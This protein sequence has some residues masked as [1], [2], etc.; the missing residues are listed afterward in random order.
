MYIGS[1]LTNLRNVQD[2]KTLF[3]NWVIVQLSQQIT[4]MNPGNI[5]WKLD[6]L[7]HRQ[8]LVQG[9]GSTPVVFS[10]RSESVTRTLPTVH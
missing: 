6:S 4:T 8:K 9:V 10:L 1:V 2:A 3:T 5:L 7:L